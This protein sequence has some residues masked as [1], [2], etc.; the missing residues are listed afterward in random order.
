MA[1]NQALVQSGKALYDQQAQLPDIGGSFAEGSKMIKDQ[2]EANQKKKQ[3]AEDREYELKRRGREE[4][5]RE[6]DLDA[7]ITAAQEEM[8][9]YTNSIQQALDLNLLDGAAYDSFP[10]DR[11][12]W[13]KDMGNRQKFFSDAGDFETFKKRIDTAI[14]AEG[15]WGAAVQTATNATISD[16]SPEAKKMDAAVEFWHKQNPNT[17]PKIENVNG[18][19]YF[20]LPDPSDPTNED[21]QVLIKVSDVAGNPEGYLGEYDEISTMDG[22]MANLV[23]SDLYKDLDAGYAD[24]A[25]VSQF[26]DQHV[27]T[28]IQGKELADSLYVTTGIDL[29]EVQINEIAT[30]VGVELGEDGKLDSS[31]FDL[32]NDGQITGAEKA[33]LRAVFEGMVEAQFGAQDP[34]KRPLSIKDQETLASIESKKAT[35]ELNTARAEEIRAEL[36]LSQEEIEQ[37]TAAYSRYQNTGDYKDLIGVGGIV[38]IVHEP[39]RFG[40]DTYTIT[41]EDGQ[42]IVVEGELDDEMLANLA[43]VPADY[44]GY[45]EYL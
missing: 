7:K 43:G 29:S 22:V 42:E 15:N 36:N 9:V 34:S 38:N 18:N 40:D 31:D 35:T 28:G 1:V 33:K 8:G 37:S 21:A 5:L 41:T 2:I 30:G 39:S 25:A 44:D 4:Q 6:L 17:P 19:D 23:S 24:P 45:D 32:N 12:A 11:Q 16:S 27:T 3:E 20:V 13:W 26:F 10:Q 14:Q